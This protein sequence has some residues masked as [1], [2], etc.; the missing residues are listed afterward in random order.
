MVRTCIVLCIMRIPLYSVAFLHAG[1]A[2]GGGGRG[3]R[4]GPPMPRGPHLGACSCGYGAAFVV[5]IRAGGSVSSFSL[6]RRRGKDEG[7]HVQVSGLRSGKCAGSWAFFFLHLSV[8]SPLDNRY[9]Y[10]VGR[11]KKGTRIYHDRAGALT[12]RHTN[13]QSISRFILG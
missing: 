8:S 9:E 2:Q 11:L 10:L 13:H 7:S 12:R 4:P 6:G 3:G 5:A 1:P